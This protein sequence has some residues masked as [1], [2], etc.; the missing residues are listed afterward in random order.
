LSSYS[1]ETAEKRKKTGGPKFKS[2]ILSRAK[3]NFS[4]L[5]GGNS[6]KT[7]SEKRR[8]LPVPKDREGKGKLKLRVPEKIPIVKLY[9]RSSQRMY[10]KRK[11]C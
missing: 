4:P 1:S 7:R 11:F 2:I 8:G 5:L 6:V 3:R 9:R 10:K